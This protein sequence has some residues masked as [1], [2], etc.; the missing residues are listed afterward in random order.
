MST[1]AKRDDSSDFGLSGLERQI[2]LS[3]LF[4]TAALSYAHVNT[5]RTSSLCGSL[6]TE[7][8]WHLVF[9]T[10]P[11]WSGAPV[12]RPHWT[13]SSAPFSNP[14]F[15]L[16]LAFFFYLS[17]PLFNQSGTT[18]LSYRLRP[19]STAVPRSLRLLCTREAAAALTFAVSFTYKIKE[20]CLYLI[21]FT[22]FCSFLQIM[23]CCCLLVPV[24]TKTTSGCRWL[25][26]INVYRM[27]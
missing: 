10:Q 19:A 25:D 8:L 7:A 1:D 26:Q 21:A 13:L 16:W 27:I 24:T 6:D 12:S 23:H 14:I 20:L 5:R 11:L 18:C 3:G 9:R 22:F 15:M 17:T 4:L 2:A